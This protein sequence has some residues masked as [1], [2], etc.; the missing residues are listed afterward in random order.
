MTNIY[1][2]L[3]VIPG[4]HDWLEDEIRS[5]ISAP[6]N[7]KDPEKIQA[8]IDE[9]FQGAMEKTSFDGAYAHIICAAV[10][11]EDEAPA[12][13]Y[14]ETPLQE[15]QLLV[16]LNDFLSQ[17]LSGKHPQHY[18]NTNRTF[19]GHNIHGFDIPMIKKRG[20]ILGVKP[21]YSVPVE[22]KPWDNNPYDTMMKWDARNFCSMDKLLKAFGLGEKG[23]VNG[24]MVYQMWK[25]G[26]HN[27]IKEYCKQDVEKVRK[28]YKKMSYQ[29]LQ[30]YTELSVSSVV[31]ADQS[32]KA[33]CLNI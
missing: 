10:A 8:Y 4:Q 5:S 33:Y 11:V 32:Q 16:D 2:D 15:K 21:H 7:Y 29:D 9:A 22:A 28:L 14:A 19:I 31:T 20:M 27:E 24:S 1:L 23:D 13:F 17:D 12:V 30:N 3:E 26:L 6:S 18:G 25:D